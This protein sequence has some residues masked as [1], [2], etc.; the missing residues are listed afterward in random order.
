MTV[1][2]FNP[3]DLTLA[4]FEMYLKFLNGEYTYE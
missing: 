1:L 2:K 4:E 3:L